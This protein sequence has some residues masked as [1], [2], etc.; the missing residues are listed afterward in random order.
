MWSGQRVDESF[1]RKYYTVLLR[2]NETYLSDLSDLGLKD[3][4]NRSLYRMGISAT[5]EGILR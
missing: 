4:L 3:P 5:V 1:K 2:D